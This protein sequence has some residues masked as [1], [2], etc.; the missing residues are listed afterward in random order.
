MHTQL[1][2]KLIFQAFNAQSE[3]LKLF[4]DNGTNIKEKERKR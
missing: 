3:E 2:A 1:D 4:A